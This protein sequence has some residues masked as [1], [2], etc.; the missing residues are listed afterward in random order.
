MVATDMDQKKAVHKNVQIQPVIQNVML[1]I[2]KAVWGINV[3]INAHHAMI[4]MVMEYVL[5]SV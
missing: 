5:I 2:V 4:V 3:L 1:W